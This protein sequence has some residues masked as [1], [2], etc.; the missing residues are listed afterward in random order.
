[1]VENQKSGKIDPEHLS[2]REFE[3]NDDNSNQLQNVRDREQMWNS[4]LL[5]QN[6]I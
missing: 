2:N 5:L 4:L 6:L 3:D 1:M